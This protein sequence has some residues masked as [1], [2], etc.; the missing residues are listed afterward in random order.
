M[1]KRQS[2]EKRLEKQRL[3]QAEYRKRKKG[4]KVAS[5]DDIAQELL[6]FAVTE[7]LNNGREAELLE[8]VE[9]IV[10]R[11]AVRG[12]DRHA[13]DR[14]FMEIIDRYQAGWDFQRKVHLLSQED[15][16]GDAGMRSSSIR[17]RH[18]D[19]EDA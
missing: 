2:R 6:H 3:Y 17:E 10:D 19:T 1:P 12:F 9:T 14:S 16:A 8:I 13:A 18:L 5:R 4:G 11:L 15:G 7:N